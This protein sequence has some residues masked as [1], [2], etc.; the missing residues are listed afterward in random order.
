MKRR[1][2]Y[3]LLSAV[4][5]IAWQFFGSYNQT[6]RLLISSPELVVQFFA[7]NAGD[8]LAATQVTFLEAVAGL[9]IAT[10]FSF[11]M[12]ILCFYKPSMMDFVLPI[13]VSSQV[14]P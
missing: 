14:V 5:L 6:V 10:A 4:L 9:S 11:A 3:T 8:L 2:L 13:M 12:M 1:L 7:R